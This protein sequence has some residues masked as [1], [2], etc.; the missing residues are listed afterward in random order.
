MQTL[1]CGVGGGDSD[2]VSFFVK[3]RKLIECSLGRLALS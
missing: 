3:V 1:V 2:G